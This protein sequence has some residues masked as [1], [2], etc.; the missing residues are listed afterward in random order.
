MLSGLKAR[1]HAAS[2]A[3]NKGLRPI[4][5]MAH[6]PAGRSDS[7]SLAGDGDGISILM[8]YLRHALAYPRDGFAIRF[9]SGRFTELFHSPAQGP[10]QP[11][12]PCRNPKMKQEIRCLNPILRT[13]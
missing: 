1:H 6:Q 2:G 12:Q 13:V 9:P 8:A 4:R 11:D 3:V 7:P 10:V 5:R